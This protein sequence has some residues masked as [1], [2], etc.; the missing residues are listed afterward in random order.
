MITV[1]SS[2][3]AMAISPAEPSCE[4]ISQHEEQ[5]TRSLPHSKEMATSVS[6]KN[7]SPVALPSIRGGSQGRRDAARQFDPCQFC[8]NGSGRTAAYE[9]AQD[10]RNSQS[11]L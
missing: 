9:L 4:I 8:L 6:S 3:A 10:L 5:E 11:A 2:S 1:T 7:K